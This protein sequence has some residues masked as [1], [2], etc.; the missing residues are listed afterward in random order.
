MCATETETKTQS[1]TEDRSYLA[2]EYQRCAGAAE[3]VVRAEK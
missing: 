3:N 1:T 2:L